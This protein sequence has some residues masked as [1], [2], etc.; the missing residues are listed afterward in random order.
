MV[1]RLGNESVFTAETRVADMPT[2][3]LAEE[4]RKTGSMNN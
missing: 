2:S 3:S 4:M 1:E